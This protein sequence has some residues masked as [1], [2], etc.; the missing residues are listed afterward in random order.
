[1]SPAVG[2]HDRSIWPWGAGIGMCG[3]GLGARTCS[4]GRVPLRFTAFALRVGA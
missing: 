4:S 2:W 3:E 1:M